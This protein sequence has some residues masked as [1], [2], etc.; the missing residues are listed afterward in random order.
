MKSYQKYPDKALLPIL[1]SILESLE[2]NEYED[3]NDYSVFGETMMVVGEV[4]TS[5]GI[6]DDFE[7]VTFFVGLLQMNPY[8]TLPLKRPILKS[9]NITHVYE[10]VQTIRETY[11]N[12]YNSF[13]PITKHML[14]D[15]QSEEIYQ[16]YDGDPVDEDVIDTDWSDD[17]ID[18]IEEV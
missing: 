3:I 4:L 1:N 9:Y 11:L 16:P 6:S 15:L 5:Y 12:T 7:D 14:M 13:I 10:K 18:G 17:W 2:E 8:L